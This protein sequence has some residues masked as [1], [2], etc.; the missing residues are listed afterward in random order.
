MGDLSKSLKDY[1]SR[2]KDETS[3]TA[4]Y[5]LLS[6]NNWFSSNS[7]DIEDKQQ[8][9]VANGWLVSAQSDPF[10]PSLVSL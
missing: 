7:E 1:M 9:E 10:C 4:K 2:S 8:T 6:T 5:S 3:S